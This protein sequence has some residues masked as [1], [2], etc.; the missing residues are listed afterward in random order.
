MRETGRA[1]DG[2]RQRRCA[3][4]RTRERNEREGRERDRA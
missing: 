1:G 4:V 3:R 2:T